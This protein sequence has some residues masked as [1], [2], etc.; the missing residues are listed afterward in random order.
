MLIWMKD[1]YMLKDH[2]IMEM[3]FFWF[4]LEKLTILPF[5]KQPLFLNIYLLLTEKHIRL[6]TYF[7]LIQLVCKEFN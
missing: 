7:F 6:V 3:I 2:I 1:F 5:I 4:L